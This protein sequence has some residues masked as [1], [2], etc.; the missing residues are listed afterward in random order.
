MTNG[1][2]MVRA[3]GVDLCVETFGAVTDPAI[4]LIGGAAASMDWW[5]DELCERLAAGQRFVIRYDHRDTGR[6]AHDPAGAPTYSGD[7]LAADAVGILDALDLVRAHFVGL[8]MGGGIAQ[9]IAIN[10][11]DRVATLTL[12]ETSPIGP[13]GHD[14]PELPPMSDRLQAYFADPPPAPDWSDRD[15]AIDAMVEGE[16]A[17]NGALPFEEDRVRA[18]AARVFD[19]THDLAATMTN[20]WI[21]EGG[22]DSVMLS[23]VKAPTLVLH[24]TADPLFPY[25]HAEALAREIEGAR[26]VPLE[27]GGHQ[28]PATPTWDLVVREILTHTSP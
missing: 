4:L 6:S 23:E 7:D 21:L 3:N 12:M 10:Q 22:D 9:A 26:L 14:R 19:R 15:A 24:G 2:Q 25:G 8:S 17:F 20:H 18:T 5:D 27:G 11:P 28:Y 13:G 16:R 1:E